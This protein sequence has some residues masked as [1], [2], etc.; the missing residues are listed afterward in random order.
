MPC[1]APGENPV[2]YTIVGIIVTKREAI[3]QQNT[4]LLANIAIGVTLGL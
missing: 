4:E 3:Y 2:N 1:I